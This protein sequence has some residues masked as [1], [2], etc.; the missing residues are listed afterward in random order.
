MFTHAEHAVKATVLEFFQTSKKYP[1]S[2]DFKKPFRKLA[3]GF[4][5]N[6]NIF[7]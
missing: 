7:I 3:N 4:K 2:K 1:Y 5:S 6:H